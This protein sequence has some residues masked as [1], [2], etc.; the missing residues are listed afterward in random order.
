MFLRTCFVGVNDL[1][2]F[3]IEKITFLSSAIGF[4]NGLFFIDGT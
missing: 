3:T 1:D 2:T 4:E